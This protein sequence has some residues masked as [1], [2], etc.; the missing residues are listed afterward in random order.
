MSLIDEV[1]NDPVLQDKVK[2]AVRGR[3]KDAADGT[4]IGTPDGAYN[5]QVKDVSLEPREA[6][7]SD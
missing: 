1:C 2:D 5:I 4:E 3:I 7:R 6:F